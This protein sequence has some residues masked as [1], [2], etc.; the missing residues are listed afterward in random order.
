MSHA[1][2]GRLERP[3]AAAPETGHVQRDPGQTERQTNTET[4]PTTRIEC[5]SPE[6]ISSTSEITESYGLRSYKVNMKPSFKSLTIKS[7]N[8]K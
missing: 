3:E 5:P 2:A 1:T 4:P 6:F 8:Q 7:K